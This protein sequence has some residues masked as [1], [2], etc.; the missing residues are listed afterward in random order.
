MTMRSFK[1][2]SEKWA[3]LLFS[4]A[5]VFTILTIFLFQSK[6]FAYE[7]IDD[8]DAMVG[9]STTENHP[10]SFVVIEAYREVQGRFDPYGAYLSSDGNTAAW[11]SIFGLDYRYSPEWE[12]FFSFTASEYQ[13]QGSTYSA[14][15]DSFGVPQLEVRYHIPTQTPVHTT[16]H[17][18]VSLP[19]KTTST[20]SNGTPD[21]SS[22]DSG[23]DGG[24]SPLSAFAIKAGVNAS[25]LV[26]SLHLRIAVE[27]S[28]TYQFAQ[29]TTLPDAPPGTP[30]MSIQNGETYQLDEIFS[31]IFNPQWSATVGFTQSWAGDTLADGQTVD[32]TASRLFSTKFGV[33]Y[34]GIKNYRFSLSY[35]SA[36]PFYQYAAN[37]PY[38]PTTSLA[39]VY[40]GF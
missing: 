27:A 26:T 7:D 13:Q 9:K 1:L 22:G 35:G 14:T 5:T 20:Q 8:L 17:L 29:D 4:F 15:T 25:T 16:L 19:F 31:Y 23:N 37:Q 21:S 32:D 33:S 38:A 10:L 24:F 12:Y 30:S 18:G 6:A 39:V 34:G 36:Y 28:T 40:N 2:S 3:D 11:V